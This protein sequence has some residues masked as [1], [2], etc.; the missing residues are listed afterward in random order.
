MW[1]VSSRSGV[2]TL[3]TAIHLLLTYL[4][5]CDCTTHDECRQAAHLSDLHAASPHVDKP[6]ATEVC[7]VWPV[8]RQTRGY[9]PSRSFVVGTT[10]F[11]TR[12]VYMVQ[13]AEYVDDFGCI[14]YRPTTQHRPI[15]YAAH[16]VPSLL[17]DFQKAAT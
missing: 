2:A 10:M 4:L 13:A 7:D 1:H 17:A 9:L 8:Q 5:N 14:G 3:R 16:A 12:S 6:K 15:L 11:A